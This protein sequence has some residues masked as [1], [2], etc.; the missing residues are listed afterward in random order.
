VYFHVVDANGNYR[1]IGQT[2]T[3]PSGFYSIAWEPDIPGKFTV[4]VS[5]A[6]TN[7]YY[8]SYA[9]SAFF[10]EEAV[11]RGHSNR[12]RTTIIND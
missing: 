8:P 10:V 3:D 9:Y 12:T 7:S 1:N 5:F 11:P 6:G 2:T 4:M